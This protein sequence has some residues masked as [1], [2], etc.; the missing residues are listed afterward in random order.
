MRSFRFISRSFSVGSFL[1]YNPKDYI[2]D[3]PD[4]APTLEENTKWLRTL[5]TK[6]KP[7][8]AKVDR[9]D[10]LPKETYVTEEKSEIDFPE[11]NSNFL[12][13]KSKKTKRVYDIVA[14]PNYSKEDYSPYHVLSIP[15]SAYDVSSSPF[16]TLPSKRRPKSESLQAFSDLK[17]VKIRSGKGGNGMVSFSRD[18]GVAVGP[19]DGGDGGDGGDIYVMAIKGLNSLHGI[20]TKYIAKD[21]SS[22]AAGQLDGK[23]GESVII[24]VP[25]GTTI[26]W[27]PSP[28]EIR[29]LQKEGEDKVFH[30]KAVGAWPEDRLPCDIQLLRDSYDIGKGWIFKDKD[31]AYH[32]ERGYFQKLR[33]SVKQFDRQSKYDEMQTD[34]FPID[35]LDFSEP[36]AEPLLLLRGGRGGLGN[37]HFLTP[38]IRNPRFAKTGRAGLEQ[39]FIFELKLLADL[40]L[41][42]LPNAGKSTLLKAIS[43]ATPKVGNW[44]FTTL[45]P[46]IGTI[47]LRI[48]QP[49]FTVADIPGIVQGAKD[50]KGMGLSFLRHIERSGGIVFVVSLG[51]KDPV[52]DLKILEGELGS[53][54]LEG[55]NKL[56]VATKADLD[57]AERSFQELNAY[58][59]N[60]D[61]KCVP[62]SPLNAGNIET[63]LQLMAECTGK[64]DI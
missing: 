57:G 18:A 61:Y 42:G 9:Y 25:V 56:V 46:T 8:D 15:V 22:G 11:T 16:S 55:K 52:A 60:L 17:V 58:C 20:K 48:D 30:V 24:T 28:V 29:S 33:D 19:P 63:V 4:N 31:E 1:R 59:S 36:T 3:I 54:R 64:F 49:P 26:R 7:E 34:R 50:N 40:G 5:A 14:G 13:F 27:C 37:M 45:Q 39:S 21:G 10:Q 23:K 32:L 51:N 47:S 44:K 35:G 62:C 38:E 2:S 53:E 6:K 12:R 43:R 41:V